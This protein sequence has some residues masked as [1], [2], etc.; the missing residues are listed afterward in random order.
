MVAVNCNALFAPHTDAG[1]GFG[2]STS[3]IVG[4][5]SYVGGELVVEGEISDIRYRP[6][7]FDGWNQRHWTLPFDGERF[8]VVW[9]TPVGCEDAAPDAATITAAVEEAQAAAAA[10]MEMV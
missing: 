7:E 9:F 5:G 10:G 6:L 1:A 4:L 3:L 2:Q 8:S